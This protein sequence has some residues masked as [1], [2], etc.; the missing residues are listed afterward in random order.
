MI[1]SKL[2]CYGVKR[3]DASLA[4]AAGQVDNQLGSGGMG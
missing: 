3:F 4:E 2:E 1:Q